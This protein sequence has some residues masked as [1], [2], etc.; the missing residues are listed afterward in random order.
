MLFQRYYILFRKPIWKRNYTN[1]LG[2]LLVLNVSF[3]SVSSHSFLDIENAS[4]VCDFLAVAEQT[5]TTVTDLVAAVNRSEIHLFSAN[6]LKQVAGQLGLL[7]G[8]TKRILL[9]RLLKYLSVQRMVSQ[10]ALEDCIQMA[11]K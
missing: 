4:Y 7:K 3:S 8:G 9:F 2:E 1:L 6:R 11:S 5:N 10:T